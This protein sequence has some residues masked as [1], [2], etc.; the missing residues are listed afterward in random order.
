MIKE[1]LLKICKKHQ[2]ILKKHK[3]KNAHLNFIKEIMLFKKNLK[4]QMLLLKI[5]NQINISLN[6]K[7]N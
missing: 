1:E 3:K 4:L 6:I 2:N 7:K 5:F